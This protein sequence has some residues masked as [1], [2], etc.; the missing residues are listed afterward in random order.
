MP[1][2]KNSE[3]CKE[4]EMGAEALL[5]FN[6]SLELGSDHLQKQTLQLLSKMRYL[7]AQYIPFFKDELWRTLAIQANDKAQEIVFIIKM[8]PQ[9]SLSYPV[10]TNQIFFTAPKSWIPLFQDEIFCYPWDQEKNE[11][12]FITSWNTSAQD[13]KDI[14]S[15]LIKKSNT[16]GE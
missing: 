1:L 14:K 6:P 15:T 5:I 13:I 3:D 9:L 2:S 11:I 10:E 16:T 7:S 12:R 4:S 8:I